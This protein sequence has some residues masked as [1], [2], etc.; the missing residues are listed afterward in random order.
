MAA[1]FCRLNSHNQ[2]VQLRQIGLD[3]LP[4]D[5]KVN[6]EVAVRQRVAHVGRNCQWKLWMRCDK[7]WVHTFYV[8]AGFTNHFEVADHGVLNQLAGQKARFVNAAYIGLDALNS[9]QNVP[10]VVR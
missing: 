6:L 3:G 10:Q 2:C 7:V 4:H 9:L 1:I 8:A 5:G